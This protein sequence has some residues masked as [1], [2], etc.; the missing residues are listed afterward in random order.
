[1]EV[2]RGGVEGGRQPHL[3]FVSFQQERENF[4]RSTGN[5]GERGAK[6]AQ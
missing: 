4:F 6:K 1:M 3:S 5:L 2:G